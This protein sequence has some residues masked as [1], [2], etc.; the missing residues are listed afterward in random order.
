MNEGSSSSRDDG[1]DTFHSLNV[2]GHPILRQ[3]DLRLLDDSDSAT[4]W[5]YLEV[6]P[7]D[8]NVL[9]IM[10]WLTGSVCLFVTIAITIVLLAILKSKPAMKFG[11]NVYLVALMIPD[12][13]HTS[14]SALIWYLSAMS[15]RYIGQAA[16]YYQSWFTYFGLGGTAW[17]NAIV[18]YEL[19][20]R[21]KKERG[22][23]LVGLV[24]MI[25]LLTEICP[26]F[27][28]C[29]LSTHRSCCG[30]R[31][32]VGTTR[33]PRG[34]RLSKKRRLSTWRWAWCLPSRFGRSNGYPFGPIY[35]MVSCAPRW[36]T[37]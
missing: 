17:I 24:T 22:V 10:W 31:A 28:T 18:A 26:H 13:I 37:T 29:I 33:R 14:Q 25:Y 16:C 20:V 3:S 34:R 35:K 4:R 12:W 1:N 2:L 32:D 21:Q 23:V 27:S 9:V 11:F 8:D 19:W 5:D 15:D 7:D 30:I 36:I 6:V